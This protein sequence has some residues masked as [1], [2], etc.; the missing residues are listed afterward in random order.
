MHCPGTARGCRHYLA[1]QALCCKLLPLPACAILMW[2]DGLYRFHV[3]PLES[4]T[5]KDIEAVSTVRNPERIQPELKR[6][7]KGLVCLSYPYSSAKNHQ[8]DSTF[9]HM[10]AQGSADQASSSTSDSPISD[11]DE[12]QDDSGHRCWGLA[13]LNAPGLVT[14][15]SHIIPSQKVADATAQTFWEADHPFSIPASTPHTSVII[16]PPSKSDTSL[17]DCCIIDTPNTPLDLASDGAVNAVNAEDVIQHAE[18]VAGLFYE[19]RPSARLKPTIM[20]FLVPKINQEASN[21]FSLDLPPGTLNP[22]TSGAPIIGF[23][24]GRPTAYVATL[25][26][27]EKYSLEPRALHHADLMQVVKV[28]AYKRQA[29]EDTKAG[30]KADVLV[31][32]QMAEELLRESSQPLPPDTVEQITPFLDDIVPMVKDGKVHKC[33]E[34]AVACWQPEIVEG[35]SGTLWL[36]KHDKQFCESVHGLGRWRM[37]DCVIETARIDRQNPVSSAKK[38]ARQEV[39]RLQTK[40]GK[41][42]V[43]QAQKTLK[44]QMLCALQMCPVTASICWH[45]QDR[46]LR[47]GIH[48]S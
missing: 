11:D 28:G 26:G 8:P 7:S 47:S 31:F 30:R 37:K 45:P 43:K 36:G 39:R 1:D 44:V 35:P 46:H 14:T 10:A 48:L 29:L 2:C 24:P 6:I 9:P 25:L 17:P 23:A 27:V 20:V 38:K 13:Q 15:L 12:L 18:L 32:E 3:G 33:M 22:N 16:P 42:E 5:V 21:T 34:E 19:P 4:L 41:K 40:K